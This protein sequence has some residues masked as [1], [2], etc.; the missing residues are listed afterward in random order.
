MTL[1]SI[2]KRKKNYSWLSEE[3]I[4]HACANIDVKPNG[5]DD[6]ST[7]TDEDDEKDQHNT[8]E[9]KPK[10]KKKSFF[11]SVKNFIL[12]KKLRSSKVKRKGSS[13][14]ETYGKLDEDFGEL[15]DHM[16]EI[17]RKNDKNGDDTENLE[18]VMR[19]GKAKRRKMETSSKERIQRRRK[20]KE[21]D[22]RRSKQGVRIDPKATQF[23]KRKSAKKK[24]IKVCIALSC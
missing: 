15:D 24:A 10:Q 12:L 7:P 4:A 13:S 21:I 9:V 23:K 19:D 6:D 2:F 18:D 1:Q 8:Q 20:Q 11:R 16:Y 14:R 3:S 17:L 5:K 22:K